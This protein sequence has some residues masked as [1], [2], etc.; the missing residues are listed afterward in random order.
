MNDSIYHLAIE[1]ATKN[2]S[3]AIFKN[4]ELLCLC[5]EKTEEFSHSEKLHTF[6]EWALEGS[7]ITINQLHAVSVSEGP[8]SYTGLRIGV[9]AAKG[10]CFALQIPL[11][12]IQTLQ[13]LVKKVETTEVDYIIPMLDA[14]RMEVYTQLYDSK[15]KKL[16]PIEA[17]IID[18]NSFEEY[19]T[20]K[21]LFVGNGAEKCESI[22]T[23]KNFSFNSTIYPSAN[24]MGELVFEK[25]LNREFE[26]IAYF[27]P[28]YL[29]DFIA[30]KP[31]NLLEK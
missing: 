21:V 15:S 30:G 13:L 22:L 18:E 6:I 9:A 7:E 29:K 23:H 5:E 14:R 10:L 25:Y 17:K 24:E 3:V 2:C 4:K 8:G 26:D 27:E 28:L 16:S 1:T 19:K 11:I 31:K 20:K 12:S